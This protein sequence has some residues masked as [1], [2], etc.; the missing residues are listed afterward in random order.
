MWYRAV[1]IHV[2]EPGQALWATE[3]LRGH[4]QIY[5]KK[6]QLGLPHVGRVRRA[7]QCDTIRVTT[8]DDWVI[9]CTNLSIPG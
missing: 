7:R 6:D 5:V 9:G 8:P 2:Q 1:W 4:G 3:L